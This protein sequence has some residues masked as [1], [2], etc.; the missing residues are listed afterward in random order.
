MAPPGPV[1]YTADQ[2]NALS[3]HEER[4]RARAELNSACKRRHCCGVSTDRRTL[5]YIARM[6]KARQD[7]LALAANDNNASSPGATSDFAPR[8]RGTSRGSYRGASQRG[9]SSYAG[10]AAVY[11][12]YQRARGTTRFKNQSVVFMKP[13]ASTE[14]AA[15]ERTSTPGSAPLSSSHSRQNSQPPTEVKQLCAAF[16]STGTRDRLHA[17]KFSSC[18]FY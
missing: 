16:T 4:V 1:P 6:K 17:P 12:P 5:G 8:G 18:E 2:I 9:G 7:R 14:A 11:H 13:N 3:T 15:V 10:R